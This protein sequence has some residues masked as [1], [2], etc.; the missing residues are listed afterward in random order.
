MTLNFWINDLSFYTKNRNFMIHKKKNADFL[1]NITF[2]P[3]SAWAYNFQIWW[4]VFNKPM[5]KDTKLAMKQ[6]KYCKINL[7]CNYIG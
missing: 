5:H 2:S 4:Y 7:F 1:K 6:S 3:Q